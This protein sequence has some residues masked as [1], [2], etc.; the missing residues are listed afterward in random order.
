MAGNPAGA[1]APRALRVPVTGATRQPSPR[2]PPARYLRQERRGVVISLRG[3]FSDQVFGPILQQFLFNGIA[4][5]QPTNKAQTYR[6]G[7]LSHLEHRDTVSGPAPTA[8]ENSALA[9][10]RGTRSRCSARGQSASPL[11]ARH[12]PTSRVAGG[13]AREGPHAARLPAPS[14]P[15]PASRGVWS[16]VSS[17]PPGV[18]THRSA[19]LPTPLHAHLHAGPRMDQVSGGCSTPRSGRP[20]APLHAS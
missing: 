2:T 3:H 18:H 1:A 11:P 19:A 7:Q 4:A 5:H 13:Q 12:V 6:P 8:G 15:L 16:A 9:G 10:F 17:R 14:R 20:Q